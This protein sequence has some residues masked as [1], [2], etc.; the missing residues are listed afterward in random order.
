MRFF[1]YYP[2]FNKPSGGNKQLRLMAALLRELGVETFL[3]RDRRFFAD[4]AGFDDNV[5]YSVPVEVAPFAFEDAAAHLAP[6]EVLILP[7]VLLE[8]SLVFCR[9]WK[10]R[11]ALNNQNGF[12]ALRYRPR[13]AVAHRTFEFALANAPYVAAICLDFLGV[14][15]ER[16]FAVPHWIV[17]GPFEFQEVKGPRDLAVCYMPR[18]L[19]Q[20][21]RQ[22]RNLVLQ[23]HPDVPWVEI[24]GLPEAQ[25]AE[26]FREN[27]VFFAAQDLE[28]C[29]LTA[30]EAMSCG[31]LIAGY[32]GTAG[33]PH[34]YASPANG[35]WTADRD[36]AGG[37][38]AVRAAIATVRAGGPRFEQYLEAGRATA[39]RFTKE[40]VREALQ[41]L[42][43]VVV[44]RAYDSRKP[45]IARL[46]WKGKLQ[47]YRLLYNSDQLGW[48]G[49]FVSWLSASTKPLR[50]MFS[51][52]RDRAA[53]R[54]LP[55]MLHHE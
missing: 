50:R 55:S 4:G 8:R 45:T 25:V 49:R 1:F 27:A 36:V 19:P 16:I 24:D 21:V 39:R 5:F 31:C 3:L 6:E 30:L 9:D 37:V 2:T 17:R 26:K 46:G 11:I 54:C 7:E 42:L 22:I 14:P 51:G 33:F 13:S 20:E 38:A 40:A 53:S 48:P 47:A 43:E 41:E 28:G 32:P 12:Y 18:K 35:F 10:C 23:S 44:N 34:P 29:P 52:S 15:A